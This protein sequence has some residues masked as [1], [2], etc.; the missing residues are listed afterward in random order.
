[1]SPIPQ[2]TV[3]IPTIGRPDLAM[4][5]IRTA[6]DQTMSDLEAI[7][8]VDGDDPET[9][10]RVSSLADERLKIIIN[11]G[12]LGAAMA[13]NIGAKSATGRWIAFLDDDDEWSLCKLERQLS[14]VNNQESTDVIVTC[15]TEVVSPWGRSIRPKTIYDNKIALSEW[16]FDRRT[17][18]GGESFIQTSSLLIPRVVFDQFRFRSA[19]EHDE[20]DLLFRATR[21]GLKIVTVPEVLVR[22]FIDDQRNS[23]TKSHKLDH[24]LDWI[25]QERDALTPKAYSGYCLTVAV[26]LAKREGKFSDFFRLLWLA[27]RHGAPTFR[28]LNIYLAVWLLPRSAAQTIRRTF[29]RRYG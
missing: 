21:A 3:V 18:A 9:I 8:V 4:R 5:A 10:R 15:L 6:L 20:W 29:V 19:V 16:L 17:F 1:M 14:F 28:Q 22:Y 24:T 27:F 7:V 11:P 25:N 13:R 26:Q 23:L 2:V 12:S